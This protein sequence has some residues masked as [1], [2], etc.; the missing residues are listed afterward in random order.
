M[1]NAICQVPE[2]VDFVGEVHV[3]FG[4]IVISENEAPILLVNRVISKVQSGCA[5]VRRDSE[6]EP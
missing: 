5:V 1:P 6:T 2:L 3:G 4:R